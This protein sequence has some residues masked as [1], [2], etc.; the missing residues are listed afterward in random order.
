[1]SVDLQSS[2]YIIR[3]ATAES[4]YY[5]LWRDYTPPPASRNVQNSDFTAL[6]A[7]IQGIRG[8]AA[9]PMDWNMKQIEK[10]LGSIQTKTCHKLGKASVDRVRS[11]RERSHC[12]DKFDHALTDKRTSSP[13]RSS[14]YRVSNQLE[15]RR[16]FVNNNSGPTRQGSPLYNKRAVVLNTIRIQ[17]ASARRENLQNRTTNSVEETI[18]HYSEKYRLKPKKNGEQVTVKNAKFIDKDEEDQLSEESSS[19]VEKEEIVPNVAPPKPATL[20]P[21]TKSTPQLS[22]RKSPISIMAEDEPD[23]R[24]GDMITQMGNSRPSSAE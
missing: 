22:N 20:V 7:R 9:L 4:L 18:R 12:K 15:D 1:M 5:T 8:P 17:S 6:Q 21:I 2:S 10:M 24:A 23:C 16:P 3:P 19:P 14:R 11:A 13:C